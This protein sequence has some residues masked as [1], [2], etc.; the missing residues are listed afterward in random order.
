MEEAC[1]VLWKRNDKSEGNRRGELGANQQRR[2][3]VRTKDFQTGHKQARE[4]QGVGGGLR[5]VAEMG[6]KFY[7]G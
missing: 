4:R 1:A 6:G 7:Q 2:V 3:P 5:V